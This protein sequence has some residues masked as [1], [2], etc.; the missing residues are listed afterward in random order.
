MALIACGA[1][2][3][4][5]V[6]GSAWRRSLVTVLLEEDHV[7]DCFELVDADDVPLVIAH[8]NT[9]FGRPRCSDCSQIY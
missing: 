6:G 9:M 2:E 7:N 8:G 5:A 4:C 3:V 1:A